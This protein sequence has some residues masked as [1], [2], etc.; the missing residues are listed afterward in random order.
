MS[1]KNKA[2]DTFRMTLETNPRRF[3]NRTAQ[4]QVVEGVDGVKDAKVEA[5]CPVCGC[6]FREAGRIGYGQPVDLAET[7]G[8]VCIGKK[9]HLDDGVGGLVWLYTHKVGQV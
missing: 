9:G 3:K 6:P 8:R 4:H 1:N 5:V 7:D 2:T